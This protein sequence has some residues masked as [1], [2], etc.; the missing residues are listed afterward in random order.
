MLFSKAAHNTTALKI[1]P[2]VTAV[3]ALLTNGESA[4][5]NEAET[6]LQSYPG[7]LALAFISPV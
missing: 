4:L 5:F 6:S 1:E 7:A 3:S 2:T